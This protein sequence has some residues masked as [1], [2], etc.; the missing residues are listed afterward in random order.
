MP[1]RFVD[2][3]R[4]RK[5]LRGV[6]PKLRL[7]FHWLWENCDA[8]GVWVIDADLFKFECGY[9][10]DVEGL[11]K[12][13]PRLE[14]LATGAIRLLDFIEVNYGVLK[15]GYNPH[16]PVFRSLEFHRISPYAIPS[17]E[18]PKEHVQDLPNPSQRVE[19]EDE[20]EGEGTQGS[21]KERARTKPTSPERKV[22]EA[23]LWPTFDDFWEAYERKGNKKTS[24]AEWDRLPQ[25]DREAIMR[26]VPD[27]VA[28]KPDKQFRKDGERYLKHRV[29]EDEVIARTMP[30]HGR[31][32]TVE[33]KR[34]AVAD[35][36]AQEYAA[37]D[38]AGGHQ[39]EQPEG[40]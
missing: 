18:P 5:S 33:Q 30:S 21:E 39:H 19:E 36:F 9:K 11:L 31:V 27:Y 7:A 35:I 13:C 15:P 23:V 6:D 40:L 38:A 32:S 17:I 34:Q 28:A 10:L 8:A 4:Y 24:A 2:T 1:K 14:L 37:E 29:W 25:K 12:T 26:A 3:D 16:K 20:E 22:Y